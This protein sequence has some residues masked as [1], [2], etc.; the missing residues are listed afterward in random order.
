MPPRETTETEQLIRQLQRVHE[1]EPWY[2]PSRGALLRDV[3]AAEAAWEPGGGAHGIWDQVL[4][5]RNWTR[6]VEA[7]ITGERPDGSGVPVGGDWPER[8]PATEA[9][10]R[11]TLESLDAAHASLVAVIRTL[12][13]ERLRSAVGS[14]DAQGPGSRIS[15]AATL[16]SIA[17][18]DV[19]HAG[20][21]S[22]LKRLARAA[23][24]GER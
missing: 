8:P 3:T 11:E 10:W 18:H 23:M 2:G 6:E 1:G 7:R 20:Q 21:V 17:D 16:R 22:L 12:T 13:P 5:M 19:Y 15:V 14:P 4:H 9:A 24:Q